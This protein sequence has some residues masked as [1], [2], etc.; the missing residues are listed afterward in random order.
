[1]VDAVAVAEILA[2]LRSKRVAVISTV[3]PSN[4]PMSAII[5]YFVDD[6]FTFYF[7]SKRS[8]KTDNIKNNN[9]VSLVIGNEDLPV[10]VQIQG[11][12]E[13]IDS[14]TDEY[15]EK[16]NQLTNVLMQSKFIPPIMKLDGAEIKIYK[17]IPTWMRWLDQ[18]D[19]NGN[20]DFVQVI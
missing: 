3:S 19:P 20:S 9:E 11:K 14:N 4:Q 16:K 17:I 2:Y 7:M 18:R 13:K 15:T 1:M 6:N 10:T 5:Y 12:A 8:R